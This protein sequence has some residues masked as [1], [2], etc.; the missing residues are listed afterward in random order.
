MLR[1]RLIFPAIL[2]VLS[3]CQKKDAVLARV[4]SRTVT[5]SEFQREI[6][7]AQEGYLNTLP[8]KKELLELLVRR[9]ILLEEANRTGLAKKPEV[10]QKLAELEEEFQR[11][12]Q[13]ARD[14]ILIGELLRS[15]QEADLKVSEEDVRRTWNEE[16]EVRASHILL[17]ESAKAEDML[18]RLAKGEKFEELARRF[19]EDKGT[20][21]QGGDLGYV[22]QG[23]LVPEFEEALFSLKT[24]ETSPAVRSPFGHHII[25]RTGERKLS[26]RPFEE[27]AE[28]LRMALEKRKFLSW[29]D[30]ARQR[31][32]VTSDIQALETLSVGEPLPAP[33]AAAP[34]Q[35][36][37]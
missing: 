19:S 27:M 37:K 22:T 34:A 2:I 3:A 15:L 10:R 1:F 21:A 16:V 32:D 36:K 35:G 12:K 8:G 13:E 18:A 30:A 28:P 29:L 23:S 25:R 11:Q 14:R 31:Y 9:E 33:P 7:G 6:S 24:G 5:A 17:P 26:Q 20:G 4:G